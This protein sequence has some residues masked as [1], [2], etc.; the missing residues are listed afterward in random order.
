MWTSVSP[1]CE[2]EFS[3][4]GE[5]DAE[6]GGGVQR[7]VFAVSLKARG[8]GAQCAYDADHVDQQPCNTHA[9]PIY[10]V[11]PDPVEDSVGVA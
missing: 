4:W 6:C 11:W 5:C 10:G 2:G 1:W 3:A 9:C 8:A 7:R